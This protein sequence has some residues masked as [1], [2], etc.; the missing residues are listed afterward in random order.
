MSRIVAPLLAGLVGLAVVIGVGVGVAIPAAER[1]VVAALEWALDE[2]AQHADTSGIPTEPDEDFGEVQVYDVLADASL[3]PAA[4]GTAAEVW[5]LFVR[6]VGADAAGES[7]IQYRA[8]DA[9]DSD[10]LAY[11]Y[12]D[13][14]P[15]YWTLAVNLAVADDP[16][17]LVATLIHEY[18]HVLSFDDGEFVTDAACPTLA[19][20]EGC[21]ADDSY[22]WTFY[23][24]F[25][26]G[27]PDAVDVE[28]L[29]P[30]LAWQFYETYE[31]DFV[32]DY[33]ATNLGED[34]AESFMTYV[35]EDSADGPT[36]AAQKL[37]FFDRYPELEAL[38][39]HI[40]TELAVELGLR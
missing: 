1:A 11:V 17:L 35:I 8:G 38:R 32:S 18:A 31:E 15:Q 25:W 33:A 10:T 20:V 22:L 12:Q 14:D 24:T 30:D 39:E 36:V 6:M 27:Y 3:E 37:R 9:P 19:L 2:P 23:D 13:A 40:R 4:S 29:D 28:N 7:I 21:A 26:A 16:Q 5:Q 34:L